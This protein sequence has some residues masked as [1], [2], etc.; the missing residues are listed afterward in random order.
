M[1]NSHPSSPPKLFLR[2]FRWFCNPDYA[3]DI[4]GDLLE[5]FDQYETEY[6]PQKAKWKFILEVLLLFRPGIIRS[7][8][9]IPNLIHPDMLKQNLKIGYR[10][11]LKD[12]S[13]SLLK[14]GGFAIGIAAFLLLSLFVR[15]ELSFDQ[16]Y[17]NKDRVYRLL[18]VTTNPDLN[19]RRWTSFS[20]QIG[21]LLNEDYPEIE[22]AGRLIVRDWYLAGDNQFRRQEVKQSNYE[23]GF[24]YGDPQLLD[25]LEIPLIYGNKETALTKPNT[26]ILSKK[27]AD[28]YFP[29][30]NPVGKTVILSDFGDHTYVVDGVMEDLSNSHLEFEFLL[31]LVGVEF[32][33]GE[34][35]SW[36][37]QNYDAYLRVKPGTNIPNLEKNLLAIKEDYILRELQETQNPVADIVSKHR[38]FELQPIGDIYLKNDETFDNFRHNEIRT[39]Q[40]FAAIG[41]FILLL[42]CINFINLYTAKSA[43]RAKEVGVRKVTGSYRSDLIRQFLT[44]STLYSLISVVLGNDSYDPNTTFF[45]SIIG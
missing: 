20:A 38:S 40:L 9:T 41:F 44:E 22:T 4:E 6:G 21:Q 45:Q 13:Y 37:C 5:R 33:R 19:F 35:T 25:I 30:E 3:E 31:T 18:N 17:Q 36:C 29:N 7:F 12:K 43:N 27:K 11:L 14:I 8:N 24:A 2:F 34:Q 1:E 32:W 23:D 26:I 39:I 28:L 16:H 10:N 15:D 42:A